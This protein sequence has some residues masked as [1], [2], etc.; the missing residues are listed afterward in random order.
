MIIGLQI[1][2]LLDMHGGFTILLQVPDRTE[3]SHRNN[4]KRERFQCVLW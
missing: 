3:P 4:M 1:A 2:I